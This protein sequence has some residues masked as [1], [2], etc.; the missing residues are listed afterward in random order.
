MTAV[1]PSPTRVAIGL[2]VGGTNIRGG[3]VTERGELIDSLQLRMPPGGDADTTIA[4][5][6]GLIGRLRERHPGVEAIGAGAPGMVDFE[7]GQIKWAPNNAYRDL[8]LKK[9]LTDLTGL[10]VLVDNDANAA[11]WAEARFGREAGGERNVIVLTVGTG[12]GGGIILDGAL[13]R[14]TSGLGGEVGHIAVNPFDGQRCGCG[15]IGCLETEASGTA[16]GRIGREAAEREPSGRIAALADGREVT[17]EVVFR[18]AQEGD[19]TAQELFRRLGAYLG[20]G[21]ASLVNIFEPEVVF[22]G[23]GLVE[24]GDLLLTPVKETYRRFAY[25][26]DMRE[27]PEIVPAACGTDAG[28]IGAATLALDAASP[29]SAGHGRPR[30]KTNA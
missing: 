8:H 21:I 4:I 18:A 22:I 20:A 19:A 28:I 23:G 17:G 24:T 13:Y 2:D 5:L 11:A 12:I 30:A 10:P 1:A 27:L 14:G 6:G 7:A 15:A 3:V 29:G 9:R 16:L 26:R 25:A